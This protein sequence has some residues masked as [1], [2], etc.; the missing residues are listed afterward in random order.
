M[1]S[2]R[3]ARRS[4][5]S[6]SPNTGIATAAAAA[7]SDRAALLQVRILSSDLTR[8]RC[9]AEMLDLSLAEYVRE[10]LE[11]EDPPRGGARPGA[12]RSKANEG[13]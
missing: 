2:R 12:G 3:A 6:R 4:V 7:T 13:R 11:A 5:P 8:L 1:A 9:E 10:R